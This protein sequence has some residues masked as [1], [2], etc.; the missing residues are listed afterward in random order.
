MGSWL[1]ETEEAPLPLLPLPQSHVY[2]AALWA[3]AED[4][5]PR[6]P[7]WQALCLHDGLQRRP[8]RHPTNP[9]RLPRSLSSLLKKTCSLGVGLR[10]SLGGDPSTPLG[11]SW[12]WDRNCRDKMEVALPPSA[13]RT[14]GSSLQR[15]GER[16]LGSNVWAVAGRL[17]SLRG[18]RAES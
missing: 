18:G 11:I 12:C 13:Q 15:A 5:R 8:P 3:Q 7:C 10:T 9:S 6:V 2:E 1:E 14:P 4:H 17:W 16:Q